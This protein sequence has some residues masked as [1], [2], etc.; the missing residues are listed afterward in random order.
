MGFLC[1]GLCLDLGFDVGVCELE[2]EMADS[3]LQERYPIKKSPIFFL[4]L[5]LLVCLGLRGGDIG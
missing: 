1:C 2:M 4:F 5:T 3:A